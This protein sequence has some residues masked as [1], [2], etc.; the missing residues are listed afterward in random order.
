[1]CRGPRLRLKHGTTLPGPVA[2]SLDD[3]VSVA[4]LDRDALAAELVEAQGLKRS[5][6]S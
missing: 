1:M 6:W 4:A 3:R 2:V 5:A